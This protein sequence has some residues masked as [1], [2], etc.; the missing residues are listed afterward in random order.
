MEPELIALL[1]VG[2]FGLVAFVWR[3]IDRIAAGPTTL[4]K[5]SDTV[6]ATAEGLTIAMHKQLKDVEIKVQQLENERDALKQQSHRQQA[7]IDKLIRSEE[8]CQ[9]QLTHLTKVV[10]E[11]RK[12]Q[13]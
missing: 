8:N 13:G 10:A 6:V 11:L 7:Q 2:P 4:S 9:Y 5:A 3:V 1:I 12:R